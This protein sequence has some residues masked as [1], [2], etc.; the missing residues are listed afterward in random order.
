[1]Q[2][3]T[4]TSTRSFQK[5]RAHLKAAE[6]Y[7]ELSYA[8]RLKVGAVIVRDDRIVSIGYNGTP[9]GF[10]NECEVKLD[11]SLLVSKPEVCHAEMNSIKLLIV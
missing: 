9:T 2:I 7:S 5:I 11:D 10:D 3:I 4:D 6:A 1:M 8:K